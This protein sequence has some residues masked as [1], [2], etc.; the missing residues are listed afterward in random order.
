[1]RRKRDWEVKPHKH[2]VLGLGPCLA[3]GQLPPQATLDRKAN[4][5]LGAPKRLP[6]AC[7]TPE[8]THPSAKPHPS[9]IG[10]RQKPGQ[11]LCSDYGDQSRIKS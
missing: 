4:F 1:M 5:D 2:K 7:H 10:F 6:K 9:R 8:Q 11:Q 3:V